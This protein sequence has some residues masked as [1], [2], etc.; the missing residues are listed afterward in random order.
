[1]EKS[2]VEVE[3]VPEDPIGSETGDEAEDEAE[4]DDE[5]KIIS[6]SGV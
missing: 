4:E 2:K 1:M 3:D 5:G 6:V